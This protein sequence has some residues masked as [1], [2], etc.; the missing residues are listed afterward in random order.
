MPLNDDYPRGG[1]RAHNS[2]VGSRWRKWRAERVGA[3]VGVGRFVVAARRVVGVCVATLVAAGVVGV[4]LVGRA[5][6]VGTAT[7]AE[8]GPRSPVVPAQTPAGQQPGQS[9]EPNDPGIELQWGLE[10]IGAVEAWP[11]STGEGVT[12]AVIDS[13]A[14]LGHEDLVDRIVAHVTCLDTGG[15]P[16]NCDASSANAGQDDDGHGTHVAGIIGAE[17]G[18]GLGVAGVAPGVD[19]MVIRALR[20]TCP[21]SNDA[22]AP[23]QPCTPAGTGNDVAAAIRWATDNGADVINLSIGSSAQ[24]IVGPAFGHA[25]RYAWA[26]GV[27]PVVAAGNDVLQSGFSDEPAIVVGALN[28]DDGAALYSNGVGEAQW[29]V[30]APGGEANDTDD[31]CA[32]GGQPR[33]ILST[34]WDPDTGEPGYACLA[35]TSMAAPH[36]AGAAALLLGG[37]L[38][39]HEVVEFLLATADDIGLPG[40]DTTYGAGAVNLSRAIAVVFPASTT[41]STGTSGG[42]GSRPGDDDESAAPSTTVAP[43]VPPLAGGPAPSPELSDPSGQR[44]TPTDLASSTRTPHPMRGLLLSLAAVLAVVV[45]SGHAWARLRTAGWARPTTVRP[46]ETAPRSN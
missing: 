7:A 17:A 13:G 8:A 16:A 14:D 32:P 12:V 41:G 45:W 2:L 23:A 24:A 30:S 35:G 3:A 44:G 28:R 46:D 4:A 10:Q 20:R 6:V 33:G 9:T 5:T 36:V 27:I 1:R 37:G 15:L 22:G 31:S 18:N 40:A 26:Q 29:A 34:Y 38:P 21:S 11:V 43:A 19:L 42:N 39:P 25:L